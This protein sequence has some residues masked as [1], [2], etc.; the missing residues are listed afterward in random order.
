MRRPSWGRREGRKWDREWSSSL[1]YVRKIEVWLTKSS[2]QSK[3]GYFCRL[4]LRKERRWRR[5]G[6]FRVR[7]WWVI[8]AV[9]IDF[10]SNLFYQKLQAWEWRTTK[11]ILTVQY[12]RKNLI[13]KS[14]SVK[15]IYSVIRISDHTVDHMHLRQHILLNL[16]SLYHWPLRCSNLTFFA[17]FWSALKPDLKRKSS[18]RLKL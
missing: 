6:R 13:V 2:M 15:F 12:I 4:S 3:E 18:R 9:E 11:R 7:Y 5:R 1:Q 10:R 14:N 17:F 8:K 16:F